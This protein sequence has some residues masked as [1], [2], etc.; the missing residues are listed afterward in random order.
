MKGYTRKFEFSTHGNHHARDKM[1]HYFEAYNFKITKENDEQ[2][3]FAKK[4]SIL[5]GWRLNPLNWE[6]VVE[7]TFRE[8]DKLHVHHTAATSGYITPV[9]FA[10]L[11]ESYLLNLERYLN[12]NIDFV[13][14]NAAAIN[15]AKV[16]VMKYHGILLVGLLIGSAVGIAVAQATEIKLLGYLGIFLGVILTERIM[17]NYLEKTY[18][19][20]GLSKV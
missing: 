14:T 4:W 7:V 15:K 13:G 5:V 19:D 11:Y 1:K 20:N 10:T 8:K 18:K 16:D 17:N 6:S 12:E 2:F 3:V 9:A